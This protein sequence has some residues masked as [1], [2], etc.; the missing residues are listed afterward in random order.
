MNLTKI[1][2]IAAASLVVA[3]GIASPAQAQPVTSVY[4]SKGSSCTP[5]TNADT[6]TTS[7]VPLTVSLCMSTSVSTCGHTIVLQSAA[8]E[9]GR[10]VVTS[11]TLGANYPDANSLFTQTPLT[12]VN[13]GTPADLGG[14]T[15]SNS[16]AAAGN[17]LLAT[18]TL[19][20]QSSATGATHVLSLA[21]TS[22][23]ALVKNGDNACGQVEVPD[24]FA[25]NSVATPATYILTR[26]TTPVFTSAANTTFQLGNNTSSFTPVASGNPNPTITLVNGSVPGMSFNGTS[27]TGTPTANGTYML[28]FRATG[29]GFSDQV[30]TVN[31]TGQASQTINFPN[32]GQQQF[33]APIM[34][35][36]TG[37]GSGNPI[38]FTSGSPAVCLVSGNTLTMLTATTV[39]T[40]KCIVNA[41]QAGNANY[42][43][44]LQAQI[45]FSIIGSPP[46]APTIG[47]AING[48]G[49]ATI[50]FTAPASSGG[51]PIT[52][53]IVYCGGFSNPGLSSPITIAGLSNGTSYNCTAS[54]IND[55]GPSVSSGIVVA[56][57]SAAAPLALIGVKSRKMHA[58]V[59]YDLVIDTARVIGDNNISV[60]PR[61]IGSGFTIVFEFNG[62]VTSVTGAT[63]VDALMAAV[64]TAAMPTFAGSEVTVVLTGVANT[65]RSTITI[66]G[67]NGGANFPVALGFLNADVNGTHTVDVL[68]VISVK[69]KSGF[70]LNL[71]NNFLRDINADGT[72]NVLDVIAAKGKSGTSAP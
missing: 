3:L 39:Q 70:A 47:T 21:N 54:A 17:Q 40:G 19:A 41:N 15:A 64:G 53:Y 24:E 61:Q 29:N 46:G 12:L 2:H 18:F 50:S 62:P 11:Y 9:N 57:P 37:G 42:T 6:Y 28:T 65:K 72:I 59:P 43:A 8:A 36:A 63:S 69:G 33:G 58:G 16:F 1:F 35:S 52:G 7:G 49:Q 25:M 5:G 48:N 45:D 31:V 14:T 51:R 10:F 34:L 26:N 38:V 56:T 44:A 30:V 27:L 32:P 4:F 60:E 71:T 13:P 66:T 20:P 23:V 22:I 68:D 67:V 55:L